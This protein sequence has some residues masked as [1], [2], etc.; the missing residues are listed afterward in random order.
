MATATAFD[1]WASGTVTAPAP[2]TQITVRNAPR[3]RNNTKTV[4]LSPLAAKAL[5]GIAQQQADKAASQAVAAA[6]AKPEPVKGDVI[7]MGGGLAQYQGD[8]LWLCGKRDA[9]PGEIKIAYRAMQSE[10][11]QVKD[12]NNV[13]WQDF[14]AMPRPDFI[15]SYFG[16]GN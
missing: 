2:L 10:P 11:W 13:L 6:Q 8:G 14:A 15:N 1:A 16:K 7:E 4:N 5:A 9:K 12:V 3:R